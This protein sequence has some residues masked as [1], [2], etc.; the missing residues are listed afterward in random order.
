MPWYS[1]YSID[2]LVALSAA[3]TFFLLATFIMFRVMLQRENIQG[4]K[5]LRITD[6]L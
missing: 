1:Y 6:T 3:G 2:V 5:K 4:Q